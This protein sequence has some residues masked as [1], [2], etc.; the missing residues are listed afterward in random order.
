MTTGF[1]GFCLSRPVHPCPTLSTSLDS[2]AEQYCC[3][4]FESF[5]PCCATCSH[6]IAL[7]MQSLDPIPV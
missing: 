4:F 6:L 1:M 5:R 3:A 2:S 7:T